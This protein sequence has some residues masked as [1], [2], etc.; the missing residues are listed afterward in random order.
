MIGY[1]FE[2]C[3]WRVVQAHRRTVSS[4]YARRVLPQ[5]SSS[6]PPQTSGLAASTGPKSTFASKRNWS[7]STNGDAGLMQFG[8][9]ATPLSTA[10]IDIPALVPATGTLAAAEKWQTYCDLCA[11]FVE[12]HDEQV[13]VNGLEASNVRSGQDDEG[14]EAP[15]STPTR[16]AE[17]PKLDPLED[18][19]TRL[20]RAGHQVT[21]ARS[22]AVR[23]LVVPINPRLLRQ[24]PEIRDG[25]V[26]PK[27]VVFYFSV[28]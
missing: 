13:P 6:G 7:C 5:F 4:P 28:F 27:T 17:L 16:L 24:A 22:S 26:S 3:L 25:T 14:S 15:P 20:F 18:R 10:T 19:V 1:S 23:P 9:Q 11:Q 12:R 21:I 8:P 2:Y